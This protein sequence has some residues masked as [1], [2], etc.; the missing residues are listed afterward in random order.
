MKNPFNPFPRLPTKEFKAKR[1]Y[2][3]EYVLDYHT[4]QSILIVRV[5]KMISASSTPHIAP[6]T[7]MHPSP[8]LDIQTILLFSR[9]IPCIPSLLVSFYS[10]PDVSSDTSLDIAETR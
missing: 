3:F 2:I 8:I 6:C 5:T 4:M 10:M 7:L 1:Y 9:M